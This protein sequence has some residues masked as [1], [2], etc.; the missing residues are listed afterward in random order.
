[1]QDNGPLRTTYTGVSDAAVTSSDL[2]AAPTAITDA[3]GAAET[4]WLTD[5]TISV[6]SALAV[7]IT[8][9]GSGRVLGK[10]YLPANGTIQWTNRGRLQ[11]R[12]PGK[13]VMAQ[14]SGAGTIAITALYQKGQW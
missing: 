3:P 12:V 10:F 11:T 4:I 8:E 6:G 9:E 1:M 2:S 5:L 7:T 13:K 14:A